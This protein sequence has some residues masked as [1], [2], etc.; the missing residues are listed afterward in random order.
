MSD[1]LINQ[2]TLMRKLQR[3]IQVSPNTSSF[4][5]PHQ[6]SDFFTIDGKPII[7]SSQNNWTQI[8]EKL[9]NFERAYKKTKLNKLFLIQF[10]LSCFLGFVKFT[11]EFN[12]SKH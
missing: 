10:N 3:K 11:I 5:H 12:T 6:Y 4:G 2:F 9:K 8:S 1:Y 7:Y